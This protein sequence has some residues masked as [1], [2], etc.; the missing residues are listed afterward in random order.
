[1]VRLNRNAERDAIASLKKDLIKQVTDCERAYWQLVTAHW[2]LLI[3][4]RLYERGIR[5]RNELVDRS[6]TVK[7]VSKAQVADARARVERRWADVLRAQQSFRAASDALKIL[8]N[9]PNAT[10]GGEELL[11]PADDALDVAV[12]F[13]LADVLTAA[14]HNRPEAQQAIL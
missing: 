4:Q 3:L 13:S 10:I 9:D 2:D 7:D 5:V 1:Q 8:I 14:I 6:E 11:V 12:S